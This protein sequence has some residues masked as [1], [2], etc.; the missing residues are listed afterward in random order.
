MTLYENK[1][2][3]VLL[4][5]GGLDSAVLLGHRLKNGDEIT[6]VSFD[7]GQTHRAQELAAAKKIAEHYDVPHRVVGAASITLPSA[8]TGNIEIPADHEQSTVVPGRNLLFCAIGAAIADAEGKEAV[9]FGANGDDQ[10]VYADCR[11]KFIEYMSLA[12]CFGTTNKVSV[13]APFSILSK[14]T[15]VEMGRYLNVPIEMTYS[16]YRGGEQPCGACGAC[17]TRQEAGA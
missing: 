1:L 2:K 8:L 3:S 5:S 9:L 4:L 13:L 17:K 14:Q 10:A 15:I 11:P 6:A 16:C 12:A 7:Y